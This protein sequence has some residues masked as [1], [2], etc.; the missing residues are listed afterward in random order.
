MGSHVERTPSK[1]ADPMGEAGLTDR[2]TKNS[3]LLALKYCGGC[4]S[5]R[6]SQSHKRVC[7]KVGLEQSKQ[8]A[9]FPL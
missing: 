6:N 7:W 8:M 4:E 3:K 5:G 9:L 2:D 1:V